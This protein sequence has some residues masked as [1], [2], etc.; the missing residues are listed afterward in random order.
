MT[1]TGTTE[2]TPMATTLQITVDC[3]DPARLVAFW[4]QALHYI[5]QPPPEGYDTW[6]AFYLGIGVPPEELPPDDRDLTDRA[7]DPDGIGPALWFQE[8][9]EPKTAKNRLHLDLRVSGGRAVPLAER[10]AAVD[11]E[12]DRL[13]QAGASVLRVLSTEGIDHYAVVMQDPEGNEFCVC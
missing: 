4:T 3:A 13:R 12:V 5:P 10:R 11:P 2:E 1:V 7:V 8:V 9:P 6:R